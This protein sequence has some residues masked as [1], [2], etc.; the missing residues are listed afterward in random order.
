MVGVINLTFKKT[1]YLEPQAAQQIV[2]RLVSAG[3]QSRLFCT[4]ILGK[5]D[6]TDLS[7]LLSMDGIIFYGLMNVRSILDENQAERKRIANRLR[8]LGFRGFIVAGGQHAALDPMGVLKECP[9]IDYII[10]ADPGYVVVN[11]VQKLLSGESVRSLP[12]L[13]MRDGRYGVRQN[14]AIPPPETVPVAPAYRPYLKYLTEHHP[15]GY[16]AA[17]M[18]ASNGCYHSGCNFCSTPVFTRAIGARSFRL[19]PVEAIVREMEGVMK[20]YNVR[21]FIFEDDSFCD[22]SWFGEQRLREFIE[23]LPLLPNKPSFT[24]VL[25]PDAVNARTR[26]LY[27]ALREAGLKLVYFGV[28]SFCQEDLDFYNKGVSIKQI[29]ESLETMYELGYSLDVAAPLRIKPGF[30]PFHPY[31][32]LTSIE[33]Q[34][35]FWERYSITPVKMIAQVE[36]YPGTSLY[37]RVKKD[38]LLAP[39]TRSGFSF[40]DPLTG[41]FHKLVFNGL[42]EIHKTRKQIRNI[43]KTAFGF[44][45]APEITSDVRHIREELERLYYEFY[46]TALSAATGKSAEQVF[47]NIF[48]DYRDSVKVLMEKLE[49]VSIIDITWDRVFS[50]VSKIYYLSGRKFPKCAHP[51]YFRPCWFPAIH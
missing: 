40:Q 21:Q 25:R 9:A 50:Q 1:P 44:N 28:E 14:E 13:A 18:E 46:V 6:D 33:A 34:L 12:G 7:S 43:E 19:K 32:R 51:N 41:R 24:M 11:L 38:G 26:P 39:G 27:E 20:Q 45:F 31:T 5:L 23:L 2:G 47:D 17:A 42:K 3:I 16:L 10:T 37:R 4:S 30:L 15:P 36:V 49:A 22:P 35:S 29:I 8:E 48:I